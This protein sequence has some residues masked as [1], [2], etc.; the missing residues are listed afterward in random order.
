[1]TRGVRTS[2]AV[3]LAAALPLAAIAQQGRQQR[4]ASPTQQI[5]ESQRRLQEI[6]AE[7]SEL[8]R[9]LTGIRSRARDVSAEIRNIQRQREVS[10][11]LLRELTFQMTETQRRI[12]E[13]TEE[14]L[15]TQDELTQK[16]ALLNRRLRDIYKRGPLLTQEALLTAHSF[17]DL[18]NRYKYL[19]LVAR[20]DRELVGDV[21]ELQ[22]QLQ[23]REQELRRSY[24]D[25]GYLQNE[26]A[27][28]HNQ[29]GSMAAERTSTLSSLRSHERSAVQRI[30]ELLRDERRLT[31]LVATL[32]ARRR[33][34]ERR[35]RDRLAAAERE[36]NAA[37]AAGRPAP[38]TATPVAPRAA[39]TM[40]T[41][42]MGNLNWPAQG[43]LVYRF[44]RA[45]QTNGTAIRYN[46]IGI[47]APAGS[48]VRAVEGG[49]VE[50]AAPFEGYGP[51]VV[52]SHGGGYYSLYLY[53]KDVQVQQGATIAKG[54]VIGTVGGEN[55]PEGSHVEFQ[56]RTPGG[57]A[58]DPLAWLRS[59]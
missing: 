41:S 10:A 31:N 29:L 19:H 12:D 24:T 28:E 21:S 32:E 17:G 58:V 50:M 20:R 30:D 25:L 8:R 48:P 5:S 11:S 43:Q 1:M 7:R 37:R 46:G 15:R 47:G 57:E 55:T 4:T 27:Q 53:L 14:L 34:E 26:R 16:K 39:P 52:V 18:L 42:D 51:T 40:S 38:V 56:I 9:E 45:L 3:A 36:R 33:D 54:Q 23:L 22:R 2:V 59:R 13:T 44:G 35:E 49:K 6:R